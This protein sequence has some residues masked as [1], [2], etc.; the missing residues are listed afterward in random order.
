MPHWFGHRP[1]RRLCTQSS[2]PGPSWA[3]SSMVLDSLAYVLMALRLSVFGVLRQDLALWF[4]LAQNPLCSSG[5][6]WTSWSD[7]LAFLSA[8]ILGI[9]HHVQLNLIYLKCKSNAFSHD[10]LCLC[11]KLDMIENEELWQLQ[12]P[13]VCTP[14]PRVT[15]KWA[16]CAQL[17]SDGPQVLLL[18]C[19][20]PQETALPLVS[21]WNQDARAFCLWHLFLFR[22]I[23]QSLLSLHV[24][25]SGDFSSWHQAL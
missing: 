10:K 2:S 14:N 25:C 4:R 23:S 9:S 22:S 18:P 11:I 21:P 6:L 24:L 15:N 8:G 12:H 19:S 3:L 13:V 16:R 17:A 5:C 1:C 7:C 20:P